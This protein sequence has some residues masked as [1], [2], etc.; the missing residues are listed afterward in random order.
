MEAG[1]DYINEVTIT[2]GPPIEDAP[3]STPARGWAVLL[4]FR[5]HGS[6]VVLISYTFGLFLPFIRTELNISPM[7]A[8]LLQGVWWVTAALVSLPAGA[9]FS[10]LRPVALVLVSMVISLPFLILQ[11]LA[12]GFPLLFAARF[13]FV[14]C[15][16]ITAPARTL[17][18]QQWAVPRQFAQINSVGLSQHSV[19]L[20]LAVSTSALL[21]TVVGSWR[22]AYWIMAGLFMFQT[23]AWAIIA[24]EGRSLAPDLG[25][26]LR[27]QT[28]T[29]LK[30][31]AAYPQG[32]VLAAMMFFLSA[33]WTAIVTFLPSL[34]LDERGID[35]ILGGPLLGFLY[36]GLIPSALFGGLLARKVRNR[37]LLL[38]V[39]ALLNMVFGLA[40]I[41]NSQP[42]VLMLLITG[43]GMVWVATPA[44]NVLPFEFPG[45][46]PREVAVISS[47]VTTFSGLGFAAGPVVTGVVAQ[48]TGSVQTGLIVLCL[49]TGLGAVFSLLYPARSP[50]LGHV[51][52]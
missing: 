34:W 8:G 4:L 25:S 1:R 11:A 41:L 9:W 12:S 43:L 28:G 22:T 18:L 7:E 49:L 37:K 2:P 24:R 42:V 30:A 38:V 3:D 20:A 48:Q 31:I 23:I 27:Q 46:Q 17:L 6:S 5:A 52:I 47:L 29:P 36:Y 19:I 35:P 26:R 21:I 32:W 16:V 44:I 39:P 50:T 45:I 33:T 14:L 13:F 40:I 10:R 15:H 51:N